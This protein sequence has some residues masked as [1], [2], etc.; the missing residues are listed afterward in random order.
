MLIYDCLIVLSE[1]ACFGDDSFVILG[2]LRYFEIILF[3]IFYIVHCLP[4]Y[5]K[6]QQST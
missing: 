3:V 2:H 5:T 4:F 6:A 1:I